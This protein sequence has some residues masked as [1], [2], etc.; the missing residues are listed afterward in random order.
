[1]VACFIVHVRCSRNHD[2]QAVVVWL[3]ASIALTL[4]VGVRKSIWPV[5]NRVMMCW[6]GYLSGTRCK[7]QRICMW[8]GRCHATATATASSV[9]SLKP[10]MVF[11]RPS[12]KRFALCY[13]T[14]VCS[15]LSVCVFTTLVYGSQTVDWSRCHLL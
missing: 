13:W 14:V 6:R 7:W 1:M 11:E 12:V 15:V 9:V 2:V 4:L 10:R 8:T 5:K 3:I